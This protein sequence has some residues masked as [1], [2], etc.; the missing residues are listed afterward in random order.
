MT[1]SAPMVRCWSS[2]VLNPNILAVL[3]VYDTVYLY[4]GCSAHLWVVGGVSLGA[5]AL[6]DSGHA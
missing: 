3:G 1:K 5:L 6:H 2:F 4:E